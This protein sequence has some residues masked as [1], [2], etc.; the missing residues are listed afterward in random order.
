MYSATIVREFKLQGSNFR[1]NMILKDVY[2]FMHFTHVT[3]NFTI[4]SY[5]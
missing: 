5:K 3:I 4:S 2:L 1:N